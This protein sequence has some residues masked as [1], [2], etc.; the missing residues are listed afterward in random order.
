VYSVTCSQLQCSV[1]TD[2]A[3]RSCSSSAPYSGRHPSL[4]GDRWRRPSGS[5]LLRVKNLS[6]FRKIKW[7]IWGALS[8]QHAWVRWWLNSDVW[9]ETTILIVAFREII[10]I[11]GIILNWSIN[12]L[13]RSVWNGLMWLRIEAIGDAVG[14]VMTG[15]DVTVGL[16]PGI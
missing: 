5:I 8:M 15:R 3:A 2:S 10:V 1:A 16:S 4:H 14:A 12:E 11:S 7:M 6:V 13:G 9:W